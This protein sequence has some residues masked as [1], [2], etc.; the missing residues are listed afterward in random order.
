MQRLIKIFGSAVFALTVGAAL[1][2]VAHGYKAGDLEIGHPWARATPGGAKIGG[3]YVSVTNNGTTPDRLVGATFSD[4]DHVEIHEMRM[5]DG[6]MKMRPLPDG[7]E[8]KPG[9]T[10]KLSPENSHL[11]LMGLKA[12]LKQGD[13]IK[14]QL[15]FEKAGTVDVEFKIESIG[16]MEPA[17]AG[18]MGGD[19]MGG[20]MKMDGMKMDGMKMNNPDMDK[21]HGSH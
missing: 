14:G 5:D 7:V 21:M 12:P 2:S 11:M 20:A 18:H 1:P 19:Q 10:I 8:I 15:T 3:G 16:A 4:S 6:V 13:K 17:H 9:E